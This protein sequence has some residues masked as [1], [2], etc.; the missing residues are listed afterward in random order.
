MPPV[1]RYEEVA[2][3][4]E[5]YRDPS[6]RRS[7]SGRR[8]PGPRLDGKS[9]L[10]TGFPEK[11]LAKQIMEALREH[12]ITKTHASSGRTRRWRPPALCA[13]VRGSRC[14][15]DECGAVSGL[16]GILRV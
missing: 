4:K 14:G 11:M 6:M 1:Y 8:R 2:G 12:V 10:L 5:Q 9:V 16:V 13:A 3:L 7:R 15:A